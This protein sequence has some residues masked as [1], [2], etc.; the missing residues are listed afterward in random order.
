MDCKYAQ[1]LN[2]IEKQ[3]FIENAMKKKYKT[4]Y[5]NIIFAP[6]DNDGCI[7]EFT[8]YIYDKY[9]FLSKRPPI[10]M[11]AKFS[12]FEC[13]IKE[14]YKNNVYKYDKDYSQWLYGRLR[15]KQKENIAIQYKKEYNARRRA[16]SEAMLVASNVKV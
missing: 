1:Y 2:M 16:L 8:L 11:V 5:Q 9:A 6:S 3:H 4:R 14:I 13:E 7:M 10:Y 15:W 12:D